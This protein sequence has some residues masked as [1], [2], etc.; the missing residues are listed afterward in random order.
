MQQVEVVRGGGSTLFGSGA[1]GGVISV[2]TV[3]AADLLEPGQTMGGRVTLGY[4]SNGAQ[5]NAST[6]LLRGLRVQWTF[7]SHWPGGAV[8][9]DLTSGGGAAI[10]FSQFDSAKRACSSSASSQ[11]PTAALS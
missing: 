4:S 10:P 11:T 8:T 5:P 7:C 3:D 1:L 2:E 6:T 9:E